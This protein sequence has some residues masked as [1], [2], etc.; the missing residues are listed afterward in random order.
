MNPRLKKIYKDISARYD[1]PVDKVEEVVKHQFKFVSDVM[2]EG[3]KNKPETFKTVEAV[4]I[5]KEIGIGERSIYTYLKDETMFEKLE[6][7]QYKKVA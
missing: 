5:G 2:A 7:S 6:H 1:I 3:D 4:K